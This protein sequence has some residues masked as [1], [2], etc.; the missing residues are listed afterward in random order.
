MTE[1]E[2]GLSYACAETVYCILNGFK[3]LDDWVEVL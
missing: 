1:L 3:P 2:K